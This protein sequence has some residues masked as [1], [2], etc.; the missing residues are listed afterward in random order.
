[1]GGDQVQTVPR[2]W[3][4]EKGCACIGRWKKGGRGWGA[5]RMP[6]YRAYSNANIAMQCRKVQEG[7]VGGGL[8]GWGRG[9][10]GRSEHPS[11]QLPVMQ[12]RCGMQ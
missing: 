6:A 9:G 5:I 2:E 11:Q 1:M 4:T 3:G 12:S 10:P 7:M 8:E